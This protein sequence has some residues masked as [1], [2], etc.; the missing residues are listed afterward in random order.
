LTIVYQ[1][2]AVSKIAKLI[3]FI[4]ESEIASGFICKLVNRIVGI[5]NFSGTTPRFGGEII[6]DI[7]GK[8]SGMIVRLSL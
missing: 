4:M 3:I 8:G 1:V 7:V 6:V 5:G 2:L